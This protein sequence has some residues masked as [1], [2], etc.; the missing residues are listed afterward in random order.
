M[1]AR[2]PALFVSHGAPSLPLEDRPASRFLRAL[3]AAPPRPQ[4]IVMVAA[5]HEAASAQVSFAAQ[6]ETIHDFGGF[7]DA[8][9]AMRH[10]APDDPAL[11]RQVADLLRGAGIDADE[12]PTRGLDHGAWTPLI[13]MDPDA[14]IPVVSL[15]ISPGRDA[16]WHF[17]MGR[18]LAPLRDDGVLIIGSGAAT[19][20][21]RAFF[22]GRFGLDDELPEARAFAD[23]LAHA[24]ETGAWDD[25]PAGPNAMQGGRFNRPTDDR[26]LPLCV[27]MG[28][29]G[30]G[31]RRIHAST[32]H[33]VIAMDAYAFGGPETALAAA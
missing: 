32:N 31:A 22:K 26:I 8:L 29:G 28:A 15:S 4:A 16:R 23:A 2:S 17:A 33:G 14:R 27:A 24:L 20:N 30:A 18:A 13:L 21:L 19:H 1:T 9:R 10:R 6:P 11:A 3:G 5:H 12:H 7:P 25:V